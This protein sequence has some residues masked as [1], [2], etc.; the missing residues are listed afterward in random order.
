MNFNNLTDEQITW[1]EG[2]IQEAYEEGY[3]DGYYEMQGDYQEDSFDF[4]LAKNETCHI[5]AERYMAPVEDK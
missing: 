1:L 2:K 5:I 3:S 4:S